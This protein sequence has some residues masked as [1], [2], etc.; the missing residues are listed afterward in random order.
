M[1]LCNYLIQIEKNG[2]VNEIIPCTCI[3][4]VIDIASKSNCICRVYHRNATIGKNWQYL[5]DMSKGVI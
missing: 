3:S 2:V 4:T 1:E 5:I